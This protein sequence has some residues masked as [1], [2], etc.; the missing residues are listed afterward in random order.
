MRDYREKLVS[1]WL[2]DGNVVGGIPVRVRMTND[3]KGQSLS[4]STEIGD[5]ADLQIGIPLEAVRDIIR[6]T[7]KDS[8]NDN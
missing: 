1:G 8:A 4:L 2:S 7:E 6:V 5:E 3:D